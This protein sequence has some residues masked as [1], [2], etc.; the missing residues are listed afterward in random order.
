[1]GHGS[2]TASALTTRSAGWS[3]PS[4]SSA[5]QT[6]GPHVSTLSVRGGHLGRGDRVG[7]ETGTGSEWGSS[8]PRAEVT[9]G[10]A[11]EVGRWRN[12]GGS[13]GWVGLGNGTV[14]TGPTGPR[15][16]PRVTEV[17]PLVRHGDSHPG[18]GVRPQPPPR[19]GSPP[20]GFETPFVPF[21]DS[22]EVGDRPRPSTEAQERSL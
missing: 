7:V 22:P 2:G 14:T 4:C 10:T 11:S 15:T 18:K 5:T 12:S 6:G 1:M 21:E 17:G 9:S 19:T 3:D 16:G 8:L 13:D 20:R